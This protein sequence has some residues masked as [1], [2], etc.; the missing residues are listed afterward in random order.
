MGKN[1]ILTK[2]LA[3]AGTLLV[4]IPVLSPVFFSGFRLFSGR[5]FNF[6]YLLP[7]E[8]F[9]LALV[10][11]GLLL[12]AAWRARSRQKLIGW[13]LGIAV[14]LLVAGQAIAV[15]TGLASGA[16]EPT[17]WQ[18]MLVII[19]LVGYTLALVAVGVGG[20]FLLRDIYKK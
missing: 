10:G 2:I 3:V 7:A 20:V 11:G 16:I 1:D 13:S 17:G 6:D 4:W 18:W 12:W 19:S 14:G 9:P 5:R 15:V 8:L